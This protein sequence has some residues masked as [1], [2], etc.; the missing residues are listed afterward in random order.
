MGRKSQGQRSRNTIAAKNDRNTRKDE[1][2]I[3]LYVDKLLRISTLPPQPNLVKALD[4]QREISTITD[5]IKELEVRKNAQRDIS[6]FS[7]G[8]RTSAATIDRFTWW[9]E[10]NGAELKGTE[11]HE[12]EGFELGLKVNA[13][14]PSSS[15]VITVPRRLMITA[16]LASK[17][18]LKDLIEK[19]QILSNMPNVT[20]AIFLLYEKFKKE[21]FWGPYIDILPT[22]Y[23]T[24]LYFSVDEL[25]EL[26][27]SPT[28]DIALKQMKCIARQYAYFHKL[29]HTL[30]DPISRFM[31]EKFTYAEY[32]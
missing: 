2:D 25:E 23:T 17:N 24:V 21:S 30:D 29:F 32:W 26:K 12:F 9:V 14:I 27:G 11:I 6:V 20:L 13:E 1:K 3:T 7:V 8:N 31:R 19:D 4:N 28:L 18:E 22:E 16:D 15:L 10:E 5:K